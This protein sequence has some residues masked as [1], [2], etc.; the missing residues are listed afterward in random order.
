MTKEQ[1]KNRELLGS[2]MVRHGFKRIGS[3]WWHF[4]NTG[5]KVI[6]FW[7]FPLMLFNPSYCLAC[8][9]TFKV[10]SPVS[11]GARRNLSLM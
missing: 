3:E 5:A 4:E 11:P 7:I 2:V 9:Q 1:I 10:P 6:P 8:N